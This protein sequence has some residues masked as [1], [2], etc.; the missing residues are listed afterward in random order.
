[1]AI[2][3]TARNYS[4]RNY[5]GGNNFLLSNA[6]QIVTEKTTLIIDFN[7]TPTSQN[8]IQFIAENSIRL[9]N[10]QTWFDL[11]VVIGD[12]LTISGSRG[13]GYPTPTTLSG[14]YTVLQ[15]I[16]D[17]ITFTTNVSG[18]GLSGTIFP[19]TVGSETNTIAF[20]SNRTSPEA[21]DIYHNLINN[22]ASSGDASLID[23]E[24]NRF[25][26]VAVNS[27]AV[28]DTINLTQ[29]GNKSG[30]T[31]F[32]STLKRIAD[33]G[34][35]RVHELT[36]V[37][38]TIK[39]TDA[40][41]TKPSVLEGNLSVKPL[42]KIL[43]LPEENNPNSNLKLT[44]AIYLGNVGW[45]N[46]SYNQGLNPYTV[47]SVVFADLDGNPLATVDYSQTTRVTATISGSATFDNKCEIEFYCIPDDFKNKFASQ[48]ERLNLV[49]CFY[50]GTATTT[51]LGDVTFAT[52]GTSLGTN[53][54]VL[55]FDILP[56]S[57]FTNY[58]E[59]LPSEQRR[60][61]LTGNVAQSGGDANNNK[62]VTLVLSEG[63]LAK[64]PNQG[65]TFEDIT[66]TLLNHA[67]EEIAECGGEI[68]E[69]ECITVN[70]CAEFLG[71]CVS[72]EMT[73]EYDY[74]V[75]SYGDF[76]F[77]LEDEGDNWI[78]TLIE[79]SGCGNETECDCIKVTYKLIGEEPVTVEVEKNEDGNY[80]IE[81]GGQTYQIEKNGTQWILQDFS[82]RITEN[83][84][85]RITENS[86]NRI[87]E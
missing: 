70:I 78:L 57:D 87:I 47:E 62:S 71:G 55:V 39:L 53:E 35:K 59:N 42:V 38:S 85:Q 2:N 82:L 77:L 18:G 36:F 10:G 46:E 86:I 28:G 1:M 20:S 74:F 44:D 9:L 11:G 48:G 33:V 58:I 24:V 67:N 81:V 16:G 76:N 60:F 5:S 19:Q 23:G 8:Q 75:G 83:G 27:L 61:R 17:T 14:S 49:N 43:A 30:G 45:Y 37:Y 12:V 7:F 6:G 4:T 13:V 64:A 26:A 54:I 63:F 84:N 22:S 51:T 72:F 80:Y 29:I 25:V 41:F 66:Y 34:G 69:C 73:K 32:S 50:S 31:Y 56:N 65:G 79:G 52:V 40:D 68:G 3:I 21:V 15:I